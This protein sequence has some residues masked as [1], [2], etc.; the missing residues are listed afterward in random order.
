MSSS[1][2]LHGLAAQLK[3]IAD[4]LP[5]CRVV[6]G[7]DG[8]V[9]EIIS[10]V[11]ERQGLTSWKP[12]PTISSF[13][14]LIAKAAGHSS[15]REIVINRLDAGG[16]AVNFGDG[17]ARLGVH[18]DCF[19]TMGTPRHSAFDDFAGVAGS[20]HSWGREYGRTLAFEFADGKLMYSA[21]AQLA[22]FD[23]KLLDVVLADGV[24]AKACKTAGVIALTDWTLY[25]HMTACW[26]KLQNEVYSRLT[27]R[28]YFFID[29]VDPS[30]RSETD[31][32]EMLKALSNFEKCGKTVLGL[33]GNEA[34]ILCRVLGL[35]DKGMDPVGVKQQALALR[36]R[37][38][39]ALVLIHHL[40][41]AV[42]ADQEKTWT[43]PG[44]FCVAP[45]KST[46]AGDRFNAGFCTGLLL[47]LELLSCLNLAAA[48]TG[49]FVRQARSATIAEL[50]PFI[51]NWAKG[52]PDAA[53]TP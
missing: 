13:N 8:F 29:L 28:P 47:G 48:V 5:Q 10:V 49:L 24:Y 20:C 9:D 43:A 4:K 44:P 21:V 38:G 36:E 11:Q 53:F 37:L 6:A 3:T 27:H 46:G 31:I 41:F 45:K 15:L 12:V 34:N 39:I 33:N 23:E 40:K 1:D 18:V 51:E 2:S 25:P 42:V 26:R 52:N 16:C 22:E 7:F 35:P 17:L 32:R 50:I 19:A 14:E 30:G